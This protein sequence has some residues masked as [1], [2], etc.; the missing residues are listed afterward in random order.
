MPDETYL[1]GVYRDENGN[2]IVISAFGK[3]SFE[4]GSSFQG[5]ILPET[6]ATE[7]VEGQTLGSA[8]NRLKDAIFST[9]YGT[10]VSIRQL[11]G[12]HRDYSNNA[13]ILSYEVSYA[14]SGGVW[15][16]TIT[17]TSGQGY[18]AFVID[19]HVI[20]TPGVSISVDATSLAGTDLN[21]NHVYVYVVNTNEEPELVA[22]HTDPDLAL[23]PHAHTAEYVA[24]SVSTSDVKVYGKAEHEIQMANIAT[25]L[26]HRIFEE[27]TLYR[28][29]LDVTAIAGDVT[30]GIGAFKSIFDL[31]TTEQRQVSIDG[32]SYVLNNGEYHTDTDFS[33]STQYSTGETI[34]DNK[35]FNVV[36]GVVQDGGTD[37]HGVVQKGTDEY[38][39]LAGA[40]DDKSNMVEYHPS[41]LF[42]KSIFTAVCRV[43]VKRSG[44][45]YALQDLSGTGVYYEDLR[46]RL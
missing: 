32:V 10:T 46:G 12:L 20:R 27:G 11:A 28:S 9:E 41:D 26:F 37:I 18:L 3:I 4:S 2:R 15:I 22:S 34:S 39:N 6:N 25:N 36:I 14:V 31:I 40:L 7:I 24:G 1:P 30:I 17:D 33:F 43:I 8:S 21:P 5:D 23:L 13:S 19:D 45:S 38:V 44:T 42:M 35:Y 16:V 29:G